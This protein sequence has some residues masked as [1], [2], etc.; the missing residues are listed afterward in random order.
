MIGTDAEKLLRGAIEA[1]SRVEYETF[2][3]I[4]ARWLWVRVCPMSDGLTGLYWRDI[5]D[6]KSAE[7]ALRESEERFRQV[8]EQ[9]PL[10]MAIADLEWAFP[11]GEP[12]TVAQCSGIR[13]RT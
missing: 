6:R 13:Q 7:A 1:G 5:S 10:G 12:G 9:S 8:F 4:L 11:R 3:P 2:S